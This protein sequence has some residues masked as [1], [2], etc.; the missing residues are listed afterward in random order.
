MV[1]QLSN[2]ASVSAAPAQHSAKTQILSVVCTL[3]GQEPH[4]PSALKE[5]H[6]AVC[7][8][9]TLAELVVILNGPAPSAVT[10]LRHL[11]DSCEHLQ[12]YVMKRRVDYSTALMAGIEHAIGDWV[13]TM[14][15]EADDPSLIR[16]LFE[17]ALRE[18]AEVALSLPGLSKRPLVDTIAS[19]VFHRLFRALHGFDLASGTPAARLLARAVV[20]GLLAD[21]SPLIAFETLTGGAAFRKCVVPCVRRPAFQPRRGEAAQIRWR[22]LIGIDAAPLRLANLFSGISAAGGLSYSFYVVVIYLVKRDVVPGWTTLSLMQSAMFMMLAL[23]LWLFSEYML[24][25]LDPG[26]K[27]PRYEIAD[28]F[29]G[30]AHP[31][32]DALN[33]EAEM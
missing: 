16:R 24:M 30:R 14:D 9:S 27:R 23:V 19:T 1:A 3:T 8:L 4:F 2:I 7:G 15:L 32:D 5:L 10:T 17:A 22:T 13:A 33:V 11:A 28:E 31:G 18:R 20:N 26:S 29:R 12:I 25:L 21:D 6:E